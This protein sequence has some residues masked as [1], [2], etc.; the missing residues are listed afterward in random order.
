V[1]RNLHLGPEI[2]PWRVEDPNVSHGEAV[3]LR[4]ESMIQGVALDHLVR[5]DVRPDE[6]VAARLPDSVAGRI[7]FSQADL[8]ELVE[9]AG[10]RLSVDGR[11]V[12][13][14]P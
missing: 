3:V 6:V 7:W 10:A 14:A 2:T 12:S 13:R 11:E 9:A 4:H 8:R 5:L 1:R